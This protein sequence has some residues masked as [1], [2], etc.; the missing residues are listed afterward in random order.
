M[1]VNIVSAKWNALSIVQN[2]D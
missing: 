1:P 2:S